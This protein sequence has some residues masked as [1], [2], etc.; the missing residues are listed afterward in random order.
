MKIHLLTVLGCVLLSTASL[1][2]APIVNPSLVM[3]PTPVKTSLTIDV[4]GVESNQGYVLVALYTKASTWTKP[5]GAYATRKV[6]ARKGIVSVDFADLPSGE[7]AIAIMH[8]AD[9][10]GEMTT[11]FMGIPKE[12]YGFG[13]DARAAFSAP[14]FGESL[15]KVTG[16]TQV[17]VN[18]K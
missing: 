2:A 7:Y 8:D 14:S 16:Q 9:D 12:A 17:V 5:A 10:N 18:I 11:S 13:N 3:T 15:V 4:K 1:L 6:P